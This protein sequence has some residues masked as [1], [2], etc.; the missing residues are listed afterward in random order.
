VGRRKIPGDDF[1]QGR[2]AGAVVAN[3][4]DDL[5]RCYRV[6]DLGEGADGAVFHADAAQLKKGHGKSLTSC[7]SEF[8]ILAE[9]DFPA[10]LVRTVLAG[11]CQKRA[12]V[13][14]STASCESAPKRDPTRICNKPS[15]YQR[16]FL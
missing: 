9:S 11:L 12:I 16:Y 14:L 8:E 13:T 6:V 4:P 5:A 15:I 3:Q 1:D 2:L 10:R 7:R